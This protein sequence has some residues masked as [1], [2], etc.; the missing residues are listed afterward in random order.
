M[1]KVRAQMP[2]SATANTDQASIV[3]GLL[4]I[5]RALDGVAHAIH[6]LGNAD[7]FTPMGAI[8]AYGKHMGEKM[9]SLIDAIREVASRQ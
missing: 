2:A 8:E 7:A 4:A 5:A 6:R 1:A 9:D 3:D